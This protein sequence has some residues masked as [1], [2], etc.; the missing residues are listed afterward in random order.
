MIGMFTPLQLVQVTALQEGTVPNMSEG[1]M[2]CAMT[3]PNLPF[4][5]SDTCYSDSS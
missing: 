1:R 2:A 4:A 3:G 5:Q